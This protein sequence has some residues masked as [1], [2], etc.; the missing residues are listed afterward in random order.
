MG[1]ELYQGKLWFSNSSNGT[2]WNIYSGT[3]TTSLAANQWY[4]IELSYSGTAGYRIY[5]NGN[6]EI[7]TSNT[8][9]SY[10]SG[11]LR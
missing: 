6:L 2:S 4:D 8:T 3:G 7:S 5:L 1:L 9:K 11:A 10:S